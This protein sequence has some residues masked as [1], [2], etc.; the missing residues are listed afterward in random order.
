MAYSK[1]K[2]FSQMEFETNVVEF[3]WTIMD[4]KKNRAELAETVVSPTFPHSKLPQWSI[5]LHPRGRKDQNTIFAALLILSKG[6]TG[7]SVTVDY[8]LSFLNDQRQA[9]IQAAENNRDFKLRAGF[10][11]TRSALPTMNPA[12]VIPTSESG[13]LVMHVRITM[14]GGP[15]ITTYYH[16]NV[17]VPIDCLSSIVC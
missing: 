2:D 4:F 9:I 8:K 12:A 6:K 13:H 15:I 10:G 14:T 17:E 7:D 1:P 3:E 5:E 16:N 11:L